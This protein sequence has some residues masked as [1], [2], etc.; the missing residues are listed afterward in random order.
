MEIIF[1]IIFFDNFGNSLKN[2]N[3][4]GSLLLPSKELSEH[5]EKAQGVGAGGRGPVGI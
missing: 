3:H 2:H 4:K 1:L 5:E